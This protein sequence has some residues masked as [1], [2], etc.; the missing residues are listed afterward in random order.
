MSQLL[1]KPLFYFRSETDLGEWLQA[2]TATLPP[3]PGTVK[4]PYPLDPPGT[5]KQPYPLL[6]VHYDR[7]FFKKG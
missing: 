6:T 3:P 1:L 2:I 7:V 5:V 4:Q